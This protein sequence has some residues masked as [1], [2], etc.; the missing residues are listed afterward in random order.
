M[1]AQSESIDPSCRIAPTARIHPG[2]VLGRNVSIE[3][4]CIIGYPPKGEIGR[5]QTTLLGDDTIVRTHSVVY[6]GVRIGRGCHLGHSVWVREHTV[7]GDHV[8][9]GTDT[10]VEHHCQIGDGVRV[11]G[12]VGLGEYTIVEEGAWIGPAVTTTNVL[13]PTCER[14]KECLAGPIIRAGA[15]VGAGAVISPD[16]E[17]GERA[18]VGSGS[19]VVKSVEDGA[20]MFG[21]PAR[22]VGMTSNMTCPYDMLEDGKSPYDPGLPTR[23]LRVPS[24]D[25]AAEHQAHKQEFRLAIDRVIL[26]GRFRDEERTR[27]FERRFGETVGL[28]HVRSVGSELAGLW[29]ALAALGI[30]PGD[31]V[32]CAAYGPANVAQAI[33]LTGARPVFAEIDPRRY[34]LDLDT[35]GAQCTT[36]TKAIIASNLHGHY[37]QIVKLRGIADRLGLWLV[38]NAGQAPDTLGNDMSGEPGA[39]VVCVSFEPSGTLG[40]YG[41]GGA[42]CT[43][44]AGLAE[45]ITWLR[46][47]GVSTAF[48]GTGA[49]DALQCAVLD[50]KLP[51]L[52]DGTQARRDIA[53]RYIEMLGDLPL[54]LP[55]VTSHVFHR[56][57]VRTANAAALGAHLR[58]RGIEAQMDSSIPLHLAPAMAELGYKAGNLP[59]TE[60]LVPELLCLPIYAELTPRQSEYV[61]ASVRAFFEKASGQPE[62]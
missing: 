27:V 25:P 55:D 44:D 40:G 56:F 17:I 50:A 53:D 48:A 6:A 16:V 47:G 4:Y 2:V 61:I 43:Q 49:L 10:L 18:F 21:N 3:D 60:A 11:Q 41:S 22:R 54:V 39:H 37:G 7:L 9:I 15:I 42:V 45:H 34:S 28:D 51:H 33:R 36:R 19:V 1:V 31:E 38:E 14:A 24:T 5:S 26:S 29:L 59:I 52:A 35:L 20:V 30:G 62:A 12:K 8:S 13:H 58:D 23:A 46:D 32:V 57:V